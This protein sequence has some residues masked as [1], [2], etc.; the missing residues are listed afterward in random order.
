MKMIHAKT[1]F[2][3]QVKQNKHRIKDLA[4]RL[5]NDSFAAVEF[6]FTTFQSFMGNLKGKKFYSLLFPL[7]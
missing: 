7:Y 2:N 3:F 5:N 1:S 6:K 4:Q